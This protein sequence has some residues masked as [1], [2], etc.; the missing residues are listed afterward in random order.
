MRTTALVL[1]LALAAAV[2]MS[3][4]L[5]TLARLYQRIIA[6]QAGVSEA[7]LSASPATTDAIVTA[8][9][10][11]LW[12]ALFLLVGALVVRARPRWAMVLFGVAAVL[13]LVVGASEITTETRLLAWFWALCAAGLAG[14]AYAGRHDPPAPA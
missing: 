2:G 9:R 1:G 13:E 4:Y 14:L 12:A 6:L 5:G 3:S 7:Q 8:G 11:G 10:V